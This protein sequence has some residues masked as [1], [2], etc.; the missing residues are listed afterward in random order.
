M[1]LVGVII[2]TYHDARSPE[3]R[4]GTN[5]NPWF[6]KINS[7]TEGPQLTHQAGYLETVANF[8]V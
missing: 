4:N 1:H 5:S 3:S 2:R 6:M 7:V 8:T